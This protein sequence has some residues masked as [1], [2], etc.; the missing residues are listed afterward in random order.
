M[1]GR[2]G[3]GPVRRSELAGAWRVTCVRRCRWR[4]A[5]GG[6][7]WRTSGA[8]RA[9][10][11]CNFHGA[12]FTGGAVTFRRARLSGGIVDFAAGTVHFGGADLPFEGTAELP[13]RGVLGRHAR[14]RPG[15]VHRRHRRLHNAQF[16]GA[17][18]DLTRVTTWQAPPQFDDAVNTPPT[19]VMLPPSAARSRGR[20][21]PGPLE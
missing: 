15:R 3:A 20:T 7:P 16:T 18:L 5:R 13:R 9:G 19:E 4:R 14:L 21:N 12:Q 17:T 6:P 10:G 2:R 1:A 8:A 11:R